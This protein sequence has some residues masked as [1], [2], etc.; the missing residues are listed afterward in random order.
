MAPKRRIEK[1]AALVHTTPETLKEVIDD[2]LRETVNEL[3]TDEPRAGGRIARD[4]RRH[5]KTGSSA[6]ASMSPQAPA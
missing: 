6:R 2:V 3:R 1:L 5:R 4:V